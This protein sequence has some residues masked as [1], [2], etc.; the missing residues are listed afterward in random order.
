MRRGIMVSTKV[1]IIVL[2]I[3]L[4]N[5]ISIGI[6][7][8]MIHRDDSIK[9]NQDRIMAIAKTA[10]MSITPDEFWDALNTGNKNEHY[11]RLLIQF[12]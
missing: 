6:F 10:A 9:S 8:Y 4:I 12:L 11:E 7:S 5:T 1:T 3:I 2:I